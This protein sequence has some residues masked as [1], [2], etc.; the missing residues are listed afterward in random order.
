MVL[1]I[2]AVG[3]YSSRAQYWWSC[4]FSGLGGTVA[5][6]LGLILHAFV[7]PWIL[8]RGGSDE[9]AREAYQQFVRETFLMHL[10]F[11]AV[12][13]FVIGVIVATLVWAIRRA[14]MRSGKSMQQSNTAN[15]P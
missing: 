10:L 12:E 13:G 1:F 2:S 14:V 15:S 4:L 9:G 3:A 8:S 11:I 5:L 7:L 6:W